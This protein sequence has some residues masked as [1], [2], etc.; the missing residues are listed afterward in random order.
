MLGNWSYLR[1]GGGH[2]EMNAVRAYFELNWIP[3]L[4]EIFENFSFNTPRAKLYAKQGKNYHLSWQILLMVHTASLH[5]LVQPYVRECLMLCKTDL[6][7][8]DLEWAR[9]H[10]EKN[11]GYA[12]LYHM[13]LRYSQALIN[14]RAGMRR[15]NA[16]LTWSAKYHIKE[17]FWGRNHP[18]YQK[19]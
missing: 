5:E 16:E 14:F 4:E 15:N 10:K 19:I 2:Y 9:L 8:K 7:V 3:F 17:L 12:Y 1:I 11:K 18:Y 6:S 13:T